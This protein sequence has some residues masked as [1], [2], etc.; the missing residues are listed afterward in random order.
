VPA[1]PAPT[2]A[3]GPDVT[4]L[5]DGPPVSTTWAH[6]IHGGG[7][8]RFVTVTDAP[9]LF[10]AAP[11][12]AADGTLSFS[13]AKDA[14][15]FANVAVSA[16]DDNGS[17]A[18]HTLH[19]TITPVNDAPTFT[20][21]G[22][23]ATTEGSGPQTVAW[24]TNVSPGPP[25]ESAQTLSF[26]VTSTNPSLFSFAGQPAVAPDGTLSYTPAFAASGSATV[27][28]VLHD[29]GGTANG[30]VDTS[31]PATFHIT[32]VAVN[33][34]PSFDNAGDV[35]SL[36]DAGPQATQWATNISPGP[37]EPGQTVTFS[38]SNDNPSLF[39]AQPAISPTGVLTYTSA[40]NANGVAV[41][42]VT[43]RDN[44]GTANGGRDTATATFRIT[45]SPVNDPPT[46]TPGSNQSV[47]EDAGAQSAQW[48][49][50][51]S[52][53][54]SDES[55]QTVSFAVTNNNN[56]LFSVQPSLS[57]SGVLT[58]TP[59]ANAN[60]TATVSVTPQDNGG[61]VNGGVDTGS[62]QTFTIT[63][64]AV[65]D[66][67]T[68]TAG[69]SQTVLEDAGAQSVQWAT[70]ISPGPANESGQTVSFSLT[71][72]N[73]ALFS[74][75]PAIDA[76]G[77][78]TYTPAPNANGTANVTVT[79]QD[80]GGTAFGGQDTATATF[81]IDVTAVNDAPSF[82]A[83]A[84][85]AVAQNASAQTVSGWGTAISAGP[86][87]EAGQA[88]NFTVTND[89]NALFSAQ[90]AVSAAGTLTYTPAPGAYG[91]A[92]VS[93]T[94]HDNGGTANG[95]VDTSGTQTFTISVERPPVASND[96][97]SGSVGTD[98]A[99]NV[100]DND[101]DPDGNLASDTVSLVS[102]PSNGSLTLN[103]DGTFVYT[104]NLAF[105]GTDS[106]TY[107]LTGVGGSS[108]ATV[109]LTVN[110][111]TVTTSLVQAVN[112][113]ATAPPYQFTSS[114]FTPSSGAVYLVF[115]GH[116]SSAGDGAT[117]SAS[118]S[119]SVTNGGA[120]ITSSANSNNTYGWVWEVDG[121][122]SSSS[123]VTV[124][125]TKPNSKTSASDVMDIVQVVSSSSPAYVGTGTIYP[126]PK[127]AG[128]T[129]TSTLT[130]PSVGDAEVS[131][132]YVNSFFNTVDPGWKTAGIA[133]MSGSYLT[134]GSGGTGFGALVAYAPQALSTATT[135][136]G[137]GPDG[138]SYV[139]I[140]FELKP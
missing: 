125:F 22:D 80:D 137:T 126:N 66:P 135:N 10:A 41:V 104:P 32:V 21:G 132:L 122:G 114:S 55:W 19:I 51:I 38:T 67:P 85:Q 97:Y 70:S 121:T 12:V 2:F 57:S 100:T 105:V 52:P 53:G 101:S 44:G 11:V 107:T 112:G 134:G 34:P 109:S 24:A 77:V 98:I 90:P 64:T 106:F 133:T 27:T 91:L 20:P 103:P 47:L 43:A 131:F 86:P 59:A 54:P 7:H 1:P 8:L 13:P 62:T 61:T 89:N 116:V 73:N 30:G 136:K 42:S 124:S 50:N 130:G 71:N 78:L 25:N 111:L 82:T 92:N 14:F 26:T 120:P 139:S 115:V 108:T 17:S 94:L 63:V 28:V 128:H 60:G 65:N 5:E 69:G 127:V 36:E 45:V 129:L 4:V 23:V 68:F 72:D 99:G 95:G 37:S 56:A 96:S 123:S 84:N 76:A 3:A 74:T 35:G 40:A 18:V 119:L 9:A 48:A 138:A 16:V 49:T 113:S 79:A 31:A 93:V 58:Y 140:S 75:Q 117:L 15:G 87:D 33:Q 110:A 6:D 102:G 39:I 88:L 46:F 118:G 29:N 81:A 83:G